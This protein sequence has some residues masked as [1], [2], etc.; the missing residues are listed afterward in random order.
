MRFCIVLM[1]ISLMACTP[2][3]IGWFAEPPFKD[4]AVNKYLIKPIRI[5]PTYHKSIQIQ[6]KMDHIKTNLNLA[7]KNKGLEESPIS[8]AQFYIEARITALPPYGISHDEARFLR[9]VHGSN[10]PNANPRATSAARDGIE[11]YFID[12]YTD[13]E[14]WSAWCALPGELLPDYRNNNEKQIPELEEK[15]IS[16]CIKDMIEK[17]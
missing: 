17:L 3:R 1:T 14:L 15:D 5:L 11:I 10:F 16:Q 9:G 13:K 6:S 2:K 4:Y 7:L 12:K 8:S